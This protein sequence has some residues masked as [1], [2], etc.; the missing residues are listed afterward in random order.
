MDV[1]AKLKCFDP[2]LCPNITAGAACPKNLPG[3]FYSR[4]P[5]LCMNGHVKEISINRPLM[6]SDTDSANRRARIQ[7][8]QGP[9]G[10]VFSTML[11]QLSQL[12]VLFVWDYLLVSGDVEEWVAAMPTSIAYVSLGWP[13]SLRGRLPTFARLTNLAELAIGYS[14]I[15]GTIPPAIGDLP[16][17]SNLRL[18][19]NR[20]TGT[21]PLLNNLS[22]LKRDSK[23][24]LCEILSN[25]K[26]MSDTNCISSCS[27]LPECCSSGTTRSC[28]FA[29][30]PTTTAT[31]ATS[32]TQP[33]FTLPPSSGVSSSVSSSVSQSLSTSQTV[34]AAIPQTEPTATIGI[35]VGVSA[36]VLLLMAAIALLLWRRKRASSPTSSP[37]TGAPAASNYGVVP[38]RPR[39][40]YEIGRM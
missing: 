21:V 27:N 8:Q 25:T 19:G 14:Q 2:E 4:A 32:T 29:P 20:L 9:G 5:L 33:S 15:S 26:F 6:V 31:T 17:L 16:R 38:P 30:D 24:F 1:Y 12:E 23:A 3:L 11:S 35:A 39:A 22:Q 28:T 18:Y 7:A 10:G 13:M 34:D 37:S 36:A 40:D